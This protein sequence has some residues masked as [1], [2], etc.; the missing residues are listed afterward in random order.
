MIRILTAICLIA[1]VALT[2]TTSRAAATATTTDDK[3]GTTL[4]LTNAEFA[5]GVAVVANGFVFVS[6]QIAVR[7]GGGPTEIVA[8]RSRSR[9]VRRCATS[10]PS[11]RP[12]AARSTAW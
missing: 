1:S 5:V 11:S 9:P 3:S 2:P 7:P 12:P 8:P 10:R 6:G 4:G